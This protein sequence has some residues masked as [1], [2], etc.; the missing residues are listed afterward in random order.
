MFNNVNLYVQTLI[1]LDITANQFLLCHLLY[2]DQKENGKYV[3]PGLKSTSPI[4][5]LYKYCNSNHRKWTKEEIEDLIDKE[6]LINNNREDRLDADLLDVTDKFKHRVYASVNRFE[7]LWEV[8]PAVV[9]SFDN[10]KQGVKLKVCDP[11]EMQDLYNRIVKTNKLHKHIIFL[12]EWAKKNNQL[13][14]SLAN[15]IK[16][17]HW[18]TLEELYKEYGSDNMRVAR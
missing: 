11:D 2:T 13:N 6:Y 18:E 15:F 5:N 7:E 14:V 10:S 4:A 9:K 8:Y 16:S 12:V 17:R 1:S 3:T